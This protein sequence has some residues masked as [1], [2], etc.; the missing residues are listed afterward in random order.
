[1]IYGRIKPIEEDNT[2]YKIACFFVNDIF[3]TVVNNKKVKD[4]SINVIGTLIIFINTSFSFVNAFQ[5]VCKSSI[6]KNLQKFIFI[7]STY[8]TGYIM[9]KKN[10]VF[11]SS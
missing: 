6:F 1:M 4:I 3:R 10:C 8:K 7:F 11:V 2:I 5:I 9:V